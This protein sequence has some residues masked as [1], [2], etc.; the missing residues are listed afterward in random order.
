MASKSDIKFSIRAVYKEPEI[1]QLPES[2]EAIYQTIQSA[3]EK[4]S[5][6]RVPSKRRPKVQMIYNPLDTQKL[7]IALANHGEYIDK[8]G[9]IRV[10]L[11]EKIRRFIK[12]GNK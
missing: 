7:R 9:V 10:R 2:D 8:H 11:I 5:E 6:M 4:L 12:K 1:K 3:I